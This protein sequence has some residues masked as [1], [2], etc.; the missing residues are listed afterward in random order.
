M[1]TYRAPQ[2]GLTDEDISA[3]PAQPVPTYDSEKAVGNVG[4]YEGQLVDAD[5]YGSTKRGLKSRHIQLIALGGAIGTGLFVGSGATL[6]LVGPAPLF[7]AFFVM[8]VLLWFIMNALAE[9]TTFIP[10]PGA[11]VPYYINRFFE[12]SL[13]FASGWNY[14]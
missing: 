14:W 4:V 3:K 6:S 9:M 1:D 11:S 13:G 2:K 12:P 8:S 7:M 5:R 10:I